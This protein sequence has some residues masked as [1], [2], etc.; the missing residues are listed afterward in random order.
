[1]S[2]KQDKT[3][4]K[5]P[6]YK[7]L[8][9]RRGIDLFVFKLTQEGMVITGAVSVV[10]GFV[11]MSPAYHLLVTLFCAY[12][13]IYFVGGWFTPKLDI[14]GRLPD[15]LEAGR[16]IKVRYELT[17][18]KKRAAYDVAVGLF[19]L[20]AQLKQTKTNDVISCIKSGETASYDLE[21]KP[22]RRGMYEIFGPRYFST[23]PFN[24]FRN[25]PTNKREI[26]MLVI[27]SYH[28]IGSLQLSKDSRYCPGGVTSASSVGESPEF[29]GNREFRSGDSPR[30]IDCR[31]WAR[32]GMPAIKEYNEEY[33][34][35]VALILDTQVKNDVKPGP[36]GYPNFEAAVS[37]TASLVDSISKSEDVIDV[38]AAGSELYVFRAGRNTAQFD[39]LLEVF[40][41]LEHATKD[42]FDS[43]SSSLVQELENTSSAIFVLL[44]W[45]D[46]R[47]R[48]VKQALEHD[49]VVRIILIG[50]GKYTKDYRGNSE[51]AVATY[52]ITPEMV[53]E[54]RVCFS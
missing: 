52:D 30:R 35:H 1:M 26:S 49:C 24:L 41:C 40:A 8:K 31:A 6:K 45:D 3:K 38:F 15:R 16:E 14:S 22:L 9:S 51:L 39:N 18:L 21:L 2:G 20:P 48:L 33:F 53:K 44:D 50:N 54:G 37:L 34:C 29:I 10:A 28:P 19:N 4:H 23:F 43:I 12:L 32:L 36:E 11:T 47:E 42:P 17:N 25:G 7:P 27:P 46:T 5:R 13:V